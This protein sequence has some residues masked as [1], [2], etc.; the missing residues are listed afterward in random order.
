MHRKLCALLV[1]AAL[2]TAACGAGEADENGSKPV[3]KEQGGYQ[4]VSDVAEHAA[5]GRDVAKVRGLLA[6]AK[7]GGTVDWAAVGTT[8]GEGGAS[9]K[10][11]GSPR[12]L[13]GIASEHPATAVVNAA[14]NGVGDGAGA[15]DA[16]RAQR[17]DKGITVL[18]AAKV[19]DELKAA[20]EKAGKGETDPGSGAPHNVD[21]A[22]AFFVAEDQGPAVT[23]DKRAADFGRDGRVRE[24]IVDALAAAQKAAADGDAEALRNAAGDVASGLDYVFYLATYKYLDHDGKADKRAEG[25]TF[26]LAIAEQ[27][28]SAS[29]EADALIVK[30][31]ASGD[32]A[33]GRAALHR[34]E[35]L[36]A[37]GIVD[38]ERID[39]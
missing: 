26:Y 8:F 11:D 39:G 37:L 6:P 14:I 4:P 30:A 34:P 18:L 28:R 22:W 24:P 23:A 31:F 2:A 9:R 25:E 12:T 3:A 27:V 29:A 38:S 20:E 17:V 7:E 16:V 10:G 15:E 36:S 33:A 32:A 5:I 13:A 19:L 1:S 35:V 21:E